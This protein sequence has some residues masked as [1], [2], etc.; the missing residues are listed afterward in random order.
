M[1]STIKILI[2]P[3][4]ANGYPLHLIPRILAYRGRPLASF[5]KGWHLKDHCLSIG[6]MYG[7]GRFDGMDLGFSFTGML[8][9]DLNIREDFL[10]H[11]CK[12]AWPVHAFHA[13]FG[14]GSPLFAETRMELTEDGERTR[15]GLRNQVIAAKEIKGR[16]AIMVLHLGRTKDPPQKAFSRAIRVLESVLPLAEDYGVT[17]ALENMPHCPPGESYLGADY[18]ELRQALKLLQSSFLKVCLDW[19]H[20]NNY[21][22]AFAETNS[23]EPIQEYT[24]T[25][26]YCREIINELGP[27]IVYAHIH[28]NRSHRLGN[29]EFFEEYDEHMSLCSIPDH[30]RDAFKEVIALLVRTTSVQRVGLLNLELIPRRFFGFYRTF[31]TGSTRDEQLESARLLREMVRAAHTGSVDMSRG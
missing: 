29:K 21:C 22:R 20:A 12:K 14:G 5:F 7:P 4:Y 18:R 3:L 24:R 17:L 13:T 23:R 31:P 26:G 1:D 28:Y 10:E 30:E 27:D 11:Y 19:G 2:D 15:R 6:K 25:F 8:D 9:A 16:G